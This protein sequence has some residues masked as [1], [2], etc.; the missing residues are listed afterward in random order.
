MSTYINVVDGGDDLLS[1]V[2]GQQQAGRFAFLEQQRRKELEQET[3]KQ[4]EQKDQG[5]KLDPTPFKRELIAH[6][7]PGGMAAAQVSTRYEGNDWFLTVSTA[8]GSKSVEVKRTNVRI[9]EPNPSVPANVGYG[10]PGPRDSDM[11]WD[12]MGLTGSTVDINSEYRTFT[13]KNQ[14]ISQNKDRTY[15]LPIDGETCLVV[16][17]FNQLYKRAY[18]Y[19]EQVYWTA[20]FTKGTQMTWT[21]R[22][23]VETWWYPLTLPE[24]AADPWYGLRSPATGLTYYHIPSARIERGTRWV[25]N[26]EPIERI[27][28]DVYCFVVSKRNVR[29]VNTPSALTAWMNAH[30]PPMELKGTTTLYTNDWFKDEY[31]KVEVVAP[32][33]SPPY[34]G[35]TSSPVFDN[36]KTRIQEDKSTVQITSFSTGTYVSDM[37]A[38]PAQ[39]K[40]LPLHFGLGAVNTTNHYSGAYFTPASIR[41]M[42][43]N[44]TLT[45]TK[46]NEYQHVRNTYFPSAPNLFMG[47]C[48][49]SGSC[50]TTGQKDFYGTTTQPST[51][52]TAVSSVNRINKYSV[53]VGTGS[54]YYAWDWGKPGY[55]RTALSSLG[56]SAADLK[57]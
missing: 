33:G 49:V 1:K 37:D 4:Q 32:I 17:R 24:Y 41:T 36:Q 40:A 39:R 6:R 15:V 8:D 47:A 25:K 13:A 26:G 14:S 20:D 16:Y 52:T 10:F 11:A 38:L 29:R 23:G 7:H 9:T 56:F 12:F 42:T 31:K 5:K 3:K 28:A 35:G 21:T 19:E 44:V 45:D 53:K 34:L 46:L 51:T 18:Y 54:V 43:G 48:L 57:A 22:S 50:Q 27:G 55:C 2:K 30:H